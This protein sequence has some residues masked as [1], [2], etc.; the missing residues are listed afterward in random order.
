MNFYLHIWESVHD[1]WANRIVI[2]IKRMYVDVVLASQTCISISQ[3]KT[4]GTIL[5]T[6]LMVN[7]ALEKVKG[8]N[9]G[10]LVQC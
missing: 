5:N 1:K 6:A 2:R 9:F 4:L 10:M 7:M 3:N 8:Q